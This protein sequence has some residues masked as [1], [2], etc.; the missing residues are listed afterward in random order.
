MTRQSIYGLGPYTVE[1]YAE[2]ENLIVVLGSGID[3]GNTLDDLAQRDSPPEITHRD[4]GALDSDDYPVTVPH[5]ELIDGVIHHLFDKDIDAV[6]II[7]AVTHT[8]D[9]HT[10]TFPD[11]L[12]GRER[13]YLALVINMFLVSAHSTTGRRTAGCLD[14]R[15]KKHG[16]WPIPT[17]R[18]RKKDGIHPLFIS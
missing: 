8:A 2:L 5:D 18:K 17:R 7:R 9:I 14:Y 12:Q 10:G 6:V 13:L 3:F 15:V 11:V 16:L 1:T 4:P